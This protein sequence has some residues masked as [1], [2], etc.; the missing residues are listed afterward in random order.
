M[1][2]DEI[3]GQVDRMIDGIME[4]EVLGDSA[5]DVDKQEPKDERFKTSDMPGKTGVIGGPAEQSSD[6]EEKP[7]PLSNI[8][9]GVAHLVQDMGEDLK[10]DKEDLNEIES[11][12]QLFESI[13]KVLKKIE[14][15][16]RQEQEQDFL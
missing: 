14:K 13:T 15:K 3:D 9:A 16:K 5:P 12:S 10:I 6:E 11:Y 4:E 2:D 8:L 7:N 1:S